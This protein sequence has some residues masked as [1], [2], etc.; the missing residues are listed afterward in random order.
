MHAVERLLS[1]AASHSR[2]KKKKS[3]IWKIPGDWGGE[4]RR[5][6]SSEISSVNLPL[7]CLG[8]RNVGAGSISAEPS[9]N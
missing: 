3:A 9:D 8:T 2:A 7:G 1:R 4:G 6:F 5:C